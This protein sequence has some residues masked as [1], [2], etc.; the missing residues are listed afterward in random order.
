MVIQRDAE[1]KLNIHSINLK[2]IDA[3]PATHVNGDLWYFDDGATRE[4]RMDINGTVVAF[5]IAA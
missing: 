2:P 1:S 4:L 5:A 3:D